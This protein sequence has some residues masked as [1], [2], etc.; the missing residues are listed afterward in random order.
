MV[1]SLVLQQLLTIMILII[2]QKLVLV[3]AAVSIYT[4]R[5]LR[6]RVYNTTAIDT[7]A[8]TAAATT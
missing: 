7:T 6:V 1:S 8:A 2:L 3:V 5:T 4:T